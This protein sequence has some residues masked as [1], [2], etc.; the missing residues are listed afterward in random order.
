MKRFVL[1]VFAI[2]A[3]LLSA[4]FVTA[5]GRSTSYITWTMHGTRATA[6]VKIALLDQNALESVWAQSKPPKKTEAVLPDLVTLYGD[7][8]VCRFVPGSFH[9]LSAEHGAVAFEWQTHCVTKEGKPIRASKLRTDLLFDVIAAHSALVRFHDVDDEREV[10]SVLTESRREVHLPPNKATNVGNWGATV[11]HFGRAG[12]E[13]LLTG[14]DHLAF[15]LALVLASR[16]LRTAV[17]CLTGFT[18]GHSL[19]LSLAMLGHAATKTTTV[20]TLIAA[21]IWI[22]SLE[23]V[24]MAEDRAGKRL[25]MAC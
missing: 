2:L 11:L 3:L 21:S 18:L 12:I 19:T 5:H 25:P 9:E 10:E 6:R 1:L 17:L 16:S 13:H 14:W 22:V 7:D 24:W 23:N 15:L 20:E 4:S 8:G